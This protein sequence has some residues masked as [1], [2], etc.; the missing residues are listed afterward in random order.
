MQIDVDATNRAWTAAPLRHR[1]LSLCMLCDP[2][3]ARTHVSNM[4]EPHVVAHCKNAMRDVP[5]FDI[6][7]GRLSI[8]PVHRQ[9]TAP[10]LHDETR[11]TAQCSAVTEG[12]D[13]SGFDIRFRGDRQRRRPPGK[14]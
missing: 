11:R 7:E 1:A 6:V 8:D 4:I 10:I 13:A 12:R 5:Y 14:R 9:A 3:A 2:F